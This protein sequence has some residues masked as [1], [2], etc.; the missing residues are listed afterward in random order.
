MYFGLGLLTASLIALVV[1]PAVWR[2]ATRLARAR[3]EAKV[4]MT[5][6]E[7][8]AD[9]DQLRAGF[10]ASNR[11]LEMKIGKL[12]ENLTGQVVEV[13]RKRD[14]VAELS[15]QIDRLTSSEAELENNVKRLVSDLGAT[16]EKLKEAATQ[17]T[18]QQQQ[19]ADSAGKLS[20][21]ELRLNES[22][23]LSEAQRLEHV[24]FST[25]IGNLNDK[26]SDLNQREAEA[27]ALRDRLAADIAA[28]R[29]QLEAE[30]KRAE[31]LAAGVQALQR[32]RTERLVEMERH[33]SALRAAETE[34]SA[35]QIER[36]SLI[37]RIEALTETQSDLTSELNMV[38][39]DR[40][41][42]AADLEKKSAVIA[43]VETD[44][45]TGRD[46]VIDLE[47]R[48]AKAVQH[49]EELEK[50][51]TK[52]V[53]QGTGYLQSISQMKEKSAA[54]D[55]ALTEHVET[56]SGLSD[57]RSELE[58]GLSSAAAQASGAQEVI[59][60]L[61]AR[62]AD[63]EQQRQSSLEQIATLRSGLAET[64]ALL[65]ERGSELGAL[66]AELF[67]SVRKEEEMSER[68]VSAE[69]EV[70]DA[71]AETMAASIRA[72]TQAYT[73]G[74]NVSKAIAATESKNAELTA[75]LGALEK[76]HAALRSHNTQLLQELE[77]AKGAPTGQD[78]EL[79]ERIDEIAA[80]VMEMRQVVPSSDPSSSS[81]TTEG[82]V[83]E[84]ANEPEEGE[85]DGR[86]L[87][88][89][90]RALQRP[91]ARS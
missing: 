33:G 51:L 9:K 8:V 63:E 22:R 7:I 31:G 15:G 23:Q 52:T 48:L 45:A 77:T 71:R 79:Q 41:A 34:N 43:G 13:N 11:Q 67:A 25:E 16:D 76:D 19:L 55:K 50:R 68:I 62:L 88:E 74:D 30:A 3:I 69:S 18:E 70:S 6:S 24:A 56:I 5:L 75:R 54:H 65:E 12:N 89:R 86:T 78:P 44:L 36:V 28:G 10:A 64:E 53:A 57:Q 21:T 58:A 47:S 59:A 84:G 42:K 40:A 85:S 38:N 27:L 2:R 17:M 39:E 83:G 73:G 29:E 82:R 20:T 46:R 72:R 14:Q 4:P 26:L 37:T 60:D 81:A 32:E 80:G 91:V 66:S 1:T 49:G 90:L 35:A 61:R 87:A